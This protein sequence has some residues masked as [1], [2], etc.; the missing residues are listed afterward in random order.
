MDPF[1]CANN[2]VGKV[3]PVLMS[4]VP[5]HQKRRVKTLIEC[6][7]LLHQDFRNSMNCDEIT[8]LA[9]AKSAIA[10]S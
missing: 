7:K 10:A 2:L 3:H 4:D 5:N 8:G 9:S 1:V 6:L